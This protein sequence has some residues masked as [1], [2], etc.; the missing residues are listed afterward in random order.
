MFP[1]KDLLLPW[2]LYPEEQAVEHKIAREIVLAWRQRAI[3]ALL[4]NKLP[5]WQRIW[6]CL[7]W[8]YNCTI[9]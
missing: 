8:Y 3:A 7:I 6:Q 1:P 4:P 2:A 5:W 9:S